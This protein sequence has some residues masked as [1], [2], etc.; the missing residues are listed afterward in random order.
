[1]QPNLRFWRPNSSP[2][3]KGAL[4]SEP[5]F[6]QLSPRIR[7]K[8][9]QHVLLTPPSEG[10]GT[11]CPTGD[12]RSNSVAPRAAGPGHSAKSAGGKLGPGEP[13]GSL[14]EFQG[15]TSHQNSF[16]WGELTKTDPQEKAQPFLRCLNSSLALPMS[17]RSSCFFWLSRKKY[18][19]DATFFYLPCPDYVL[20]TEQSTKN[21]MLW[22]P[23]CRPK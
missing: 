4:H 8:L 10:Q 20:S 5:V 7:T 23:R 9:K 16:G 11:C 21:K 12:M 1:M 22:A 13:A 15:C 14:L 17:S 19:N 6:H 3:P 18:K 2:S